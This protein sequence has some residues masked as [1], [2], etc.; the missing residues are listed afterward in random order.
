MRGT[1]IP[2]LITIGS[3]LISTLAILVLAST[4]VWSRHDGHRRRAREMVC[5]LL[6]REQSTTIGGRRHVPA[7]RTGR[8]ARRGNRRVTA[9]LVRDREPGR[10]LRRERASMEGRPYR[11]RRRR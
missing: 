6:R 1:T 2:I 3:W 10:S 9:N 5:L 11:N 4:Y 7:G 8:S